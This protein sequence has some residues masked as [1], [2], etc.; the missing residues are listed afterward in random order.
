MVKVMYRPLAEKTLD[1]FIK[2]NKMTALAEL[3]LVIILLMINKPE[4]ALQVFE[5]LLGMHVHNYNLI[6]Q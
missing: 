4:W 6:I 3:C 2:D 5:S 1:K